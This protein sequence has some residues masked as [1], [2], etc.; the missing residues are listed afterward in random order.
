MVQLLYVL[1]LLDRQ[2]SAMRK[3]RS[4]RLRRALPP[5]N[6]NRLTGVSAFMDLEIL[7]AREHFATTGKRTGK[8]SFACMHAHMIDQLVFRLEGCRTARATLHM[9][10]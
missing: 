9:S 8:W 6:T 1:V 3:Q 5:K 7:R 2:L 10:Q 4:F